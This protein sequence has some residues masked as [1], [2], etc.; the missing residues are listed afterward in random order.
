MRS[1][2]ERLVDGEAE[3]LG[4]AP[5]SRRV[6][7]AAPR[8][9]AAVVERAR[10]EDRTEDPGRAAIEGL[11]TLVRAIADHPR[12]PSLFDLSRSLTGEVEGEQG[13]VGVHSILL[14][15]GVD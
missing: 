4:D 11:G 8:L 5:S 2:G 3:V 6:A 12:Q 10:G 1:C 15:S 7:A 14:M 13:V 9:T